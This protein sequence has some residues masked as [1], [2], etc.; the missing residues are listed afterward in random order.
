MCAQRVSRPIDNTTVSI[1]ISN[2]NYAR[3][4]GEC[5]GSALNQDH[6]AVEV[7]VVD[8]GST[9]ES[10]AIIQS[11][12]RKIIPILQANRGQGAA[13]NA[14]FRASHGQTVIFLDAD[15]VLEK[16]AARRAIQ[17]LHDHTGISKAQF[18]LLRI[19]ATGR[20]L[21]PIHRTGTAHTI[22]DISDRGHKLPD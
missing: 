2:H 6:E 13:I 12:G 4:L 18:L 14:G 7:I 15:D 3:F 19:D 20:P 8:D 10:R 17:I 5:I 1:I 16:Q 21:D 22:S 9:D 11:Y